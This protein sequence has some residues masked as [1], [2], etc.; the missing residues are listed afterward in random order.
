MLSVKAAETLIFNLAQPLDQQRDREMVD[1]L[2]VDQR[3]LADSV[4]SSLDFPHWDNSAMDGYAVRYSDVQQ[5]SPENPAVLT[6]VVEIPA[7]YQPQTTIHPGEAARIFTGAVIP[8]GADTVVIQ[9]KT[10][11]VENRVLILEAPQPRGFVRQ[12][13]AFYRAG[14]LLLPAGIRLTATEIAILAAAQCQPIHVFRRP[15]VAIFSCGD[16]LVTPQQPLQFGQIV[17]SNLFALAALVKAAGAEPLILGIVKDD[18]QALEQTIQT[19]IAQSD[20]VISSGG[21][22]VGDYDYIDQILA[23][24][25]GIIHFRSVQMRPGKPLT[26]AEFP[27]HQALYF[28]LPGNP[29]SALVTFWRFVRPAIAKISG[30]TTGW[31]PQFI[32]VKSAGELKS[33]GKLE[34]YIWGN[35]DLNHGIYEFRPA[36]GSHSSGNLINLAQTNALAVLPVDQTLISPQ[37]DVLV[38]LI[39]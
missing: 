20:L 27:E 5:A 29:V 25:S 37:E 6:V 7:G 22:S 2:A 19:A 36:F 28:G 39:E 1:L 3:I 15:Q 13:A 8:A 18:P 35:L 4:S 23:S 33:N 34:T 9:E 21:V 26:F 17:D 11:R 10:R 30:L 31:E 14:E 12:K 32:R 16:E 38:M 24:L